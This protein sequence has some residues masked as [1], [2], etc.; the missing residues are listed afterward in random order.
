MTI[1]V[2]V[3]RTGYATRTPPAAGRHGHY[4]SRSMWGRYAH[5]E[6]YLRENSRSPCRQQVRSRSNLLVDLGLSKKKG[7]GTMAGPSN[8]P[9]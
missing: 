6:W 7:T 8:C 2:G 4:C 1:D 9:H 5:G 3:I